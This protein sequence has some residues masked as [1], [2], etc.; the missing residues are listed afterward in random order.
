VNRR[1]RPFSGRGTR[2]DHPHFWKLAQNVGQGSQAVH[3]RHFHIQDDNI[4]WLA[5]ECAQRSV[6]VHRSGH[7]MNL[8][9][10]TQGMDQQ[11][12]DDRRIVDDKYSD[13]RHG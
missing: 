2:H 10:R 9:I 3:D 5:T 4:D 12:P 8:R 6:A 7:D 1:F 11:A 13:W